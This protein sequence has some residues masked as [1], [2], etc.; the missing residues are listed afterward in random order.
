[1]SDAPR[2]GNDTAGR[3]LSNL[4]V[5]AVRDVQVPGSVNGYALGNVQIRPVRGSAMVPFGETL[6]IDPWTVGKKDV[7]HGVDRYAGGPPIRAAEA[8]PPSPA[9]P[10]P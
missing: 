4:V 8:G 2:R 1:M 3:H 10:P 6:R 9:N 5:A 7:A